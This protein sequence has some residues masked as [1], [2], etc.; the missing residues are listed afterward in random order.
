M[1]TRGYI[2]IKEN[3]KYKYIYNHNDSY[4]DGL[5]ITLY[6]YYKNVNKVKKL[7]ALGNTSSVGRTIEEG[8][9]K[10]Y[11]EHV[12]MPRE[13]RGTVAMF[14]DINR[15]KDCGNVEWEDSKPMETKYIS[16]LSREEYV[17]IF[18]TKDN[19]WYFSYSDDRYRL[20][21]L[22]KTLHSKKL[23]EKLFSDVYTKEYLPRFYNE[24]L[25]S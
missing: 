18:D 17:Y 16:N 5:G 3:G 13:C 24:C 12:S 2:A 19:R 21:D 25:N 14:R 6:K 22:E 4:I 15:W 10:S 9:S 1:S 20:R 23:L 11:V 8:G 7:I